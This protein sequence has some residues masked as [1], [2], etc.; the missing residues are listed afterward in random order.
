VEKSLGHLFQERVT[1]GV[2]KRIVDALEMIEIETMDSKA[3]FLSSRPRQRLVQPFAKEDAIREPRQGVVMR[4]TDYTG[5]RL[6]SLG[7][8]NKRNQ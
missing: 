7:N 4:H 8:V 2:A 3:I 5:L 6:L 1:D